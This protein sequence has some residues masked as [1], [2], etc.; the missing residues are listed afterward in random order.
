MFRPIILIT[1]LLS[2]AI[3]AQQKSSDEIV[4]EAN[5]LFR[6]EMASWY[7]TDLFLE[8]FSQKQSRV[9]GYFS[10]THEKLTTCVF[11]SNQ[12]NPKIIASFTF[13]STYNTQ[14]ARVDGSE[15]DLDKRELDLFTIRNIGLK[16]LQTDT[17]FKF[18]KGFNPNLIPLI[19]E[20]GKRV[21]ILTG[22]QQQGL[23]VFGNDYLLTFD[24]R[25]RL[26]EKKLLHKSLITFDLANAP[27]GQIITATMHTHLPETGEL[28]TPTDLC[29][30]MLY[31]KF[32]T[33]NTHYVFS[34]K[35]VSIWDLKK[36]SLAIMPREAWE[37]ISPKE[38]Y[39]PK[40]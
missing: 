16:E 23:I 14:T 30:L 11:Y 35:T 38:K 2:H 12:E 8:K 34:N 15:R 10:Y 18:Y 22:P 6:S 1:L 21:Y 32:T 39:L 19:D 33:W 17:L 9:G 24:K 5:K 7:G 37:K 13:D 31:G 25:S 26:K 20:K 36:G 27:E 3:Y 29:T 4:K 28:I 40:D